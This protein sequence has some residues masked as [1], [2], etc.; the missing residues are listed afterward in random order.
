[1]DKLAK[2]LVLTVEL[3]T[4]QILIMRFEICAVCSVL[5]CLAF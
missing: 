4:V 3:R 1:M 2:T 5:L